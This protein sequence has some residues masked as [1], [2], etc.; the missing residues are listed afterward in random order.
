M[1]VNK[2]RVE[3]PSTSVECYWKKPTLSRVRTTLKYIPVQQISK[4]TQTKYIS[5]LHRLY[6]GSQKKKTSTL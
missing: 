5:T 3:P 6:F 2:H 1:Q 4:K